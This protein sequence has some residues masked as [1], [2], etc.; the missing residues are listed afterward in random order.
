[1]NDKWIANAYQELVLLKP[2]ATARD[3]LHNLAKG[4]R[5][6]GMVGELGRIDI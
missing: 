3:S 4:T 1:M 2:L 6:L 5:R